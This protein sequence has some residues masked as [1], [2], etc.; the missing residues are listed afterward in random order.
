MTVPDTVMHG[1]SMMNL[2]SFA[3]KI[4]SFKGVLHWLGSVMALSLVAAAIRFWEIVWKSLLNLWICPSE[5][6]FVLLP[7]GDEGIDILDLVVFIFFDD[8]IV[9][10]IWDEEED[11][12]EEEE[13]NFLAFTKVKVE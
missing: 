9:L 13:D 3:G 2:A 6:S 4:K 11:D 7:V 5:C 1:L 10:V 8:D 12:E